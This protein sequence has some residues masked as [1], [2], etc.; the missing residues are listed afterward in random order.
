MNLEE[1][2]FV[3]FMQKFDDHPFTIRIGDETG[4]LRHFS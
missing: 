1:K 3:T 4:I 2:A